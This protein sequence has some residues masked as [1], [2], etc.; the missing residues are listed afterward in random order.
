M[1]GDD[2]AARAAFQRAIRL[3]PMSLEATAGL[4]TLDLREHK[5]A[6]ARALID[7]R[8]AAAPG[9]TDWLAIAARTY[10]AL[11]DWKAA[12]AAYRKAISIDPGQLALYNGLAAVYAGQRRLDEARA[13]LEDIVRRDPKA[14]GAQIMI[15]MI[16]NVQNKNDEARKV[17]E[18][19]LTIQPEAPVAANNL[20]WT[21]A[22]SGG[23]LDVAL[24]LAQTAVAKV[25][26]QPEFNDTLGWI[27]LKKGLTTR[28][29]ESFKVSA[30]T[31]PKTPSY[32]YH[33]GLAYM[34]SGAKDK[35]RVCLEQALKAGDF[36]GAADARKA[37]QSLKG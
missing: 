13:E 12:E 24:Q 21:Y 37:L 3:D 11:H 29:I 17:Y 31:D 9:N 6:D 7:Q 26:N 18:H 2:R 32:Q 1:R 35:A 30:E 34:K 20:A 8:L 25:P 19:I 15:A 5:E 14:V 23:N 16:L 27:Y 10:A 33:L 22:E 4:I 36:D 28:A